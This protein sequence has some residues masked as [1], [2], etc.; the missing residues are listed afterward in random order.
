[1]RA[2]GKASGAWQT[3]PK[4]QALGSLMYSADSPTTLVFSG[5]FMRIP[6]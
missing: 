3:D 4:G 2:Q 5:L 1:M 6:L